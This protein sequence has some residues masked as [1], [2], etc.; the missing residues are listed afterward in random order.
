M[1]RV[2]SAVASASLLSLSPILPPTANTSLIAA[3]TSGITVAHMITDGD[4]L[5]M[6]ECTGPL[7]DHY[8][9]VV[10]LHMTTE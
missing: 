2:L 9:D 3:G 4:V 1:S 10:L 5:C 7:P 6:E 8:F